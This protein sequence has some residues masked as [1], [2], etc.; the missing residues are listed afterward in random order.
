VA[1]SFSWW[2]ELTS[3]P[4][5]FAKCEAERIRRGGLKGPPR[6]FWCM[7]I[8]VSR[9]GARER[10]VKSVEGVLMRSRLGLLVVGICAVLICCPALA[11]QT[12]Q[13]N[14][15]ANSTTTVRG[16]ILLPDGN[17]PTLPIRFELEG[18]NGFHDILFTDSNGRLILSRLPSDISFTIFVPSDERNW[19]DTRYT[20]VPGQGADARF[21]LKPLPVMKLLKPPEYKPSA[22]VQSLHDRAIAAYQDS[23]TDEAEE[24]LRQAMKADPKYIAAFNDLGVMLMRRQKYADAE[25]VYLEGLQNNPKSV[26]LLQNLGTDQVHA[27]KYDDA[28]TT[29]REELHLQPTRGEAHLQLGAA[30]V[31]TARYTEAEAELRAAKLDTGA[32]EAGLQLYFGKLYASTGKFAKA[33]D[34]FTAYLKLVPSDSP[35]IPNIRAAMKRMQDE[36]DKSKGK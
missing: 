26:A 9:T 29:L 15:N 36:M 30:L 25:K 3:K 6:F 17:L 32:D 35:S 18:S 23:K 27:G 19:G 21:Y 33:I 28:I 11:G 20:F 1:A 10:P 22:N 24:L 34:A 5:S 31:E 16:Q 14:N 8:S 12:N 4:D 7:L 2:V 13:D